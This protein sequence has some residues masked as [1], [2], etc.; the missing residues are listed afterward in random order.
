MSTTTTKMTTTGSLDFL[1]KEKLTTGFGEKIVN[2]ESYEDV[3]VQSGLNWTVDTHPAFTEVA[4]KKIEIPN[5]NV[6][7]RNEDEK[8]L[9]IVSGKYK[10]VNNADAFSFTESIFNSKDIEFIRGGSYRGGSSTWLEARLNGK[11]SVLGDDTECYLIFMNS[12][13]G[14]GSVKALI[15]PTRVACS[16]ALNIPIKNQVRH[17][18]CVHSGDPF[19]KI[20]EARQVLLAGSSYM[21]ALNRECEVLSSIIVTDKEVANMINRLFPITDKMT[22]KQ[23]ENMELRRAQLTDVFYM[24][25]DLLDFNS[26]GYRFISA[27]A[28]YVDHAPGRKTKTATINRYMSV[29]HGNPLVDAAYNMVIA[30]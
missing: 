26:N 21:E 3:L 10:I 5:T 7:L 12:H 6:V 19:K 27:V 23:K 1:D 8:P 15:V 29:A 25:E 14:T 17:W 18:R 4:G 2:P 22:D 28:D 9:G 24:K 13:D 16:N 11:F 30:L 20:E